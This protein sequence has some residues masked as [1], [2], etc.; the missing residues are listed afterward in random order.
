M[1][2]QGLTYFPGNTPVHQCDA[3]VK[4]FALLA[5]SVGVFLVRT[6][7][8]MAVFAAVAAVAVAVA[9]IPLG[10]LCRML[11]PVW[12]LA[13]FSVLFNVIGSP[14]AH[15]LL[16][17]LFLGTRMVVL[18]VASFVVCLTT[19]SSALL[20]AFAWFIAPLR[21]LN[22][23]VDDIAFTL[24]LSLRFIPLI[25]REFTDVRAAQKSRGAE[26]SGGFARKLY[27]WGVAFASVFIG[28]FRHADT[29]ACAMDARCYGA[30]PSRTRLR[31]P[32]RARPH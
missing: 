21:R 22:V 30:G 24:A 32:R 29:L 19:A 15:G 7:W 9:R 10:R 1:Q 11:G 26:L 23:P 3:R 31:S 8:G 13:T 28:L 14:D 6:W 25:E 2:F 18:I 4:V 5:F 12:V 27:V 20:D 16:G 17:G